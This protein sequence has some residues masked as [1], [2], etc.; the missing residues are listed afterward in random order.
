MGDPKNCRANQGHSLVE[1]LLVVVVLGVLLGIALPL[2]ARVLIATREQRAVANLRAL[3]DAQMSCYARRGSFGTFALLFADND[4]SPGSFSR[5]AG[6]GFG[7]PAEG[8]SGRSRSCS[9][10]TT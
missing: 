9:P 3:S 8:A 7:G 6:S 10:T 1:L 5:R 2:F 4:L